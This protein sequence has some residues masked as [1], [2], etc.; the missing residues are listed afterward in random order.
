MRGFWKALHDP[1]WRETVGWV[2]GGVI[3][4][5]LAYDL[6]CMGVPNTITPTIMIICMVLIGILCTW[7]LGKLAAHL[8]D[9]GEDIDYPEDDD[10]DEDLEDGDEPAHGWPVIRRLD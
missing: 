4:L 8:E 7:M 6:K 3:A 1:D 9:L 5:Q 2:T 10:P